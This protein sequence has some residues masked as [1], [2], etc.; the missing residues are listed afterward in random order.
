MWR[1]HGNAPAPGEAPLPNEDGPR[2]EGG[3]AEGV[4]AVARANVPGDL[5]VSTLPCW[6]LLLVLLLG[7]GAGPARAQDPEPSSQ[8]RSE[9]LVE[10][11]APDAPAAGEEEPE[12]GMPDDGEGPDGGGLDGD[13]SRLLRGR[14]L[15]THGLDLRSLERLRWGCR[16]ETGRRD[17][18][19]FGDGTVR[20]REGLWDSQALELDRLPATD[21]Q[22]YLVRL[23]RIRRSPD[24]P[25]SWDLPPGVEG[26]WTESCELHLELPGMAVVDLYFGNYDALPLE[27]AQIEQIADELAA[28][29]QPREGERRLP[30]GYEPEPYDVLEATDGHLYR[31][32]G[33]TDDGVGIE[34]ESLVEPVRVFYRLEDLRLVFVALV[35]ADQVPLDPNTGVE[36]VVTDPPQ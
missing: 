22:N 8:P 18:T 14:A 31:V 15:D 24:F 26:R 11:F 13:E 27:L 30:E 12:K 25:E 35:P 3:V 9:P 4:V 19:L 36:L 7:L 1:T 20:L 23:V 17:L 32:V 2:V 6:G 10:L 21:L 34:V 28:N 16:N 5:V 29:M 33:T